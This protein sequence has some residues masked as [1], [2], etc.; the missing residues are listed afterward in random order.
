MSGRSE[1][2]QGA[3]AHPRPAGAPMN[4]LSRLLSTEAFRQAVREQQQQRPTPP[5]R[6]GSSG[7]PG[8]E[9]GLMVS[10]SA[11]SSLGGEVADSGGD[12][13]GPRP[14]PRRHYGQLICGC[15]G[16]PLMSNMLCRLDADLPAYLPACP[17][18]C[19]PLTRTR[20]AP[21]PPPTRLPARLPACP[22]ALCSPPACAP[23]LC[24]QHSIGS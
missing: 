7:D 24:M 12:D 1:A 19:H 14:V 2:G 6:Q 22:P 11:G 5:Q 17:P 10:F 9:E 4:Y 15:T 18:A 20:P 21:S 23:M 13:G 3:P 8:G 16:H